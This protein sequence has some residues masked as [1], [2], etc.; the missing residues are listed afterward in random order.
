[1]KKLLLLLTLVLGIMPVYS[2]NIESVTETF[3]SWFR[4][5]LKPSNANVVTNTSEAT[6]ITYTS[7]Y[8]YWN[9]G[10]SAILIASSDNTKGYISFTLPFDVSK[11]TI[12]SGQQTASGAKIDFIAGE[13]TLSGA[14]ALGK[15]GTY[16]IDIP[17]SLQASGTVYKI[18][19]PSNVSKNAQIAKIEYTKVGNVGP[20]ELGALSATCEGQAVGSTL[21]VYEGEPIVFHADNATSI[22]VVPENIGELTFDAATSS[23]TLI[24][25][26]CDNVK[27]SAVA[28]LEVEGEEAKVS[29]PLEFDL[30][31]KKADYVIA[32]W[33][34]TSAPATKSGST[35]D[36][37]LVLSKDSSRG[38]WHAYGANSYSSGI[39][40]GAQLGSGSKPF[41]NGTI[42]LSNSDIPSDAIIKGVTFTGLTNGAYTLAVSINGVKAGDIKV[43]TTESAHKLSGLELI[44]NEIVFKVTSASKYLCVKGISVKYVL[45]EE[46]P[47]EIA[48]DYTKQFC[49]ECDETGTELT[50]MDG[51]EL[52]FSSFAAARMEITT[53]DEGVEL[54]SAVNEANISWTVPEGT[55]ATIKVKATSENSTKFSE[56]TYTV[57]SE[58]VVPEVPEYLFETDSKTVMVSTAS[59]ALM[60][61][62]EPYVDGGGENVAPMSIVAQ[63]WAFT[64]GDNPKDYEFSYADMSEV[65]SV[66][67]K[68]VTPLA[69]SEAVQ[70]FVNDNGQVSGVENVAIDSEA[71]EVVYY[72][73]QG[74]R[75]EADRPGLY[76]RLVSGKAEM[77][78]V[79]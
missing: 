7:S 6:G 13:T 68:S 3:G 43:E 64:A 58:T 46:Q 39:L 25:A 49:L 50:V 18:A 44:G 27:V 35:V 74:Q 66:S 4:P 17:G 24:P 54:P 14:L 16:P 47:G 61:K 38:V 22:E 37:D 10:G 59:G 30:T 34:V 19:I 33:V 12:Y 55:I 51:T 45:P 42:T 76:V 23:A 26:I 67:A 72:N 21:E 77:V 32:D 73:L 63:D 41:S 8:T 11:I 2:Q 40:G 28:K 79:R 69:E 29:D 52:T 65:M 15:N 62:T 1:M 31:V 71:N 60:I 20:V 78:V 9:N 56:K 48:L 36:V 5:S 70:F 75:V 57:A 53:E